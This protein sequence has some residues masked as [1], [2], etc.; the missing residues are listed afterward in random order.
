[1]EPTRRSFIAASDPAA[2]SIAAAA[3]AGSTLGATAA[4]A[5]EPADDGETGRL[6]SPDPAKVLE[7]DVTVVD[8]GPASVGALLQ[9]LDEVGTVIVLEKTGQIGGMSLDTDSRARTRR[10][11]TA[12]SPAA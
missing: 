1:M 12:S 5:S 2:A 7:A 4:V 9:T 8:A 11:T 10:P 6:A 3:A